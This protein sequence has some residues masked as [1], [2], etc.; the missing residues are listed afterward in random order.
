MKSS[1][2]DLAL[3][4]MA[5]EAVLVR[6]L[7]LGQAR[8]LEVVVAAG[9]VTALVAGAEVEADQIQVLVLAT[10]MTTTLGMPKK[11]LQQVGRI[12]LLQLLTKQEMTILTVCVR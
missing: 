12:L 2:M 8:V 4:R 3:D 6:G 7:D 10:V 11:F 5:A 9:V 1:T